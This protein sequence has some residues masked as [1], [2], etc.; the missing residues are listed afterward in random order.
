M[1]KR[2]L[3]QFDHIFFV[4]T[5]AEDVRILANYG[6]EQLK[7]PWRNARAPGEPT[8]SAARAALEK[9]PKL[10][11]QLT[12]QHAEDI[13]LYRYACQLAESRCSVA[14]AL[15]RIP[16]SSGRPLPESDNF[17]FLVCCAYDFT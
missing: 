3:A 2:R 7:V 9:Y 1:A 8:W 6:W 17:D 14:P 11:A 16:P 10:V 12:Q 5:L 13:E 4:E 15:E